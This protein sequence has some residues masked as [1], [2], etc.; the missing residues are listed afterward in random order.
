MFVE[1]SSLMSYFAVFMWGLML[2]IPVVTMLIQYKDQSRLTKRVL[3]FCLSISLFS[4][5]AFV[6][7]DYDIYS[8]GLFT[9]LAVGTFLFT[10]TRIS[11]SLFSETKRKNKTLFMF[12]FAAFLLILVFAMSSLTI[13]GGSLTTTHKSIAT[14]KIDKMIKRI[15]R[16]GVPKDA[17]LISGSVGDSCLSKELDGQDDFV[18]KYIFFTNISNSPY[19]VESKLYIAVSDSPYLM[20]KL[21]NLN[22]NKVFFN[23]VDDHVIKIEKNDLGIVSFAISMVATVWLVVSLYIFWRHKKKVKNKK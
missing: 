19:K 9:P 11:F 3:Y 12:D 16:H 22:T 7:I 21:T 14:M 6:D 1:Y 8:L 4:A 2:S 5:L 18:S 17:C 23:I 15:E 13:I 20:I 10:M